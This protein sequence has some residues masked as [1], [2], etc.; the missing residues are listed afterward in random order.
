MLALAV[1]L[2]LVLATIVYL[3]IT[4]VAGNVEARR[5]DQRMA[6]ADTFVPPTTR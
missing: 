6:A 4:V 3:S 1:I 5:I 2:A